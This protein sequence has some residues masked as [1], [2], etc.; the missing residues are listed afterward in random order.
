MLLLINKI[1]II[2]DNEQKKSELSEFFKSLSTK[3]EEINF[4]PV[5]KTGL[6]ANKIIE[7]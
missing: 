7:T 3:I 1:I 2:F 4:D 6:A 5:C